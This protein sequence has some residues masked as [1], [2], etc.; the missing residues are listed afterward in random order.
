MAYTKRRSGLKRSALVAAALAGSA[1]A[2]TFR[3]TAACPN[4]G[5]IFPPV[6]SVTRLSCSD[7]GAHASCRQQDQSAFIAGQV[8]DLRVEVQAPANGTM[9]FNNGKPYDSFTLSI[10]KKGQ[11]LKD[12]TKAF[13][14][15]DPKLSS[16]NFTYYEDLFA[17]D[18]KTPTLVNVVAKDYRHLALCV[19]ARSF[20]RCGGLTV[21]RSVT[22]RSHCRSYDPG[23]Y[24]LKLK[25]NNGME[26]TA[27]WEVLPLSKKKLAKNVILFIGDGMAPGMTTA[28]RLLGH[29]SVNGKY[30]STLAL[31]KAEGFGMQ[32]THSLDS[33]ITDSANSA[34][35]LMAGKKST[36]NALN[37]YTVRC[38]SSR[39]FLALIPLLVAG[40][41][42]QALRQPEV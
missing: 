33:F 2:Q 26:E 30:Q 28:A 34:T 39:L 11:E 27:T 12:V 29:K 38:R 13:S 24:E 18:A 10:G 14:V 6:R 3:R 32:H 23:E 25:Y 4:L 41:D 17:Q 19:S 15:V 36:V 5:C 22:D 21:T 20:R 42:W 37:A 31:D 40:F 35:A 8:F 7:P 9:P 16:Y 1:S